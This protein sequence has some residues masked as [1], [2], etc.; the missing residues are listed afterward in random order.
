MSIKREY[1]VSL[2]ALSTF[3][4]GGTARE[5]A[6]IETEADLK[7]L[8]H[9]MPEGTKWIVIG[10]GSNVLF[11]DG[12][13]SVLVIRLAFS[14]MHIEDVDADTVLL[15]ADGGAP[16]DD[17]VA[18]SVKEGLSG[19]EALSLIPGTAG[20][21]PV[22]NV[23]AYGREIADVLAS[24]KAFDIETREFVTFS[25]R[26][27]EFGYRDSIFKHAGKG[28][29]IITEVT[30]ALSR[31][32]PNVPMYPGVA[33]YLA[34]HE[35]TAAS[36]LDIRNA[37]I[38]IRTKKLPD[39]KEVASVGSFFKNA[40]VPKAEADALKAKFPTLAVFPVDEKISKVGTGSLIDTLGWKG[41]RIGSF[42]LYHGNAM[43]VVH[44][45]GGTRAELEELV[46]LIQKE[47]KDAYGIAIEPEPEMLHF[48]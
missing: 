12:D 25:N 36:L 32:L 31:E 37:I 34:A 15:T 13:A 38:S 19:L 17:V 46:R 16:W 45:G 3:R 4:M 6:T 27:C 24:L 14:R 1:N 35:I 20:A 10:S 26:E 2:A 42:S 30:F 33:E 5:V 44:E 9:A 7:E 23:G 11:P 8:F 18:Y 41:K 48:G 39:P 40:F 22:Q 43:V 47:V 28:R 29:Y 21:T